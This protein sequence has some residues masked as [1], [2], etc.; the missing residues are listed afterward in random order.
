MKS[1]RSLPKLE[2]LSPKP[3]RRMISQKRPPPS[4]SSSK[5]RK[6]LREL[7]EPRPEQSQDGDQEVFLVEEDGVEDGT[8]PQEAEALGD[9]EKDPP[10]MVRAD[11]TRQEEAAS[12]AREPMITT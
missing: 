7:L 12:L 9:L 6:L 10:N 1:T 11:L 4:L 5:R 3:L 8:E 2:R